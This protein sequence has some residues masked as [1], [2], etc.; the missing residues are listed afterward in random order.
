[1]II[2]RL[3]RRKGRNKTK[4][5]FYQ[6]VEREDGRIAMYRRDGTRVHGIYPMVCRMGGILGM[7]VRCLEIEGTIDEYI[8]STTSDQ[9]KSQW[10]MIDARW[11]EF[12]QYQKSLEE[13]PAHDEISS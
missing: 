1:M 3:L 2:L 12:M 9:R 4:K 5:R 8:E 10:A 7:Y 13:I 11:K 6:V